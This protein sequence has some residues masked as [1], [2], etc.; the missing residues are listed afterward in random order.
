MTLSSMYML[1]Q[2]PRKCGISAE[3]MGKLQRVQNSAARLACKVSCRDKVHSEDLLYQL[4]WLRV[5]D[6]IVYK[7]LIIVH[8]CVYGNAPVNVR[9]LVRFSQSARMKILEVREFQTSYGERAFSVC[10]PRLWNAL[11]YEL[12][13]VEDVEV[14]KKKVK[15]LLFDGA[16]GLKKSAFKYNK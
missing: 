11:P 14:Y 9:K 3:N 8:K 15:T 1:S 6:R 2:F 12:R 13:I 16:D 7:V 4:H 5:R 10:G